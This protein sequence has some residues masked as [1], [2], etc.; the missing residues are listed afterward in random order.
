MNRLEVERCY[1]LCRDRLLAARDEHG[2]WRGELSSS[3]LSTAVAAFALRRLGGAARLRAALQGEAWL[4][5]TALADG[6]WGDTP[7]SPGNLSTTLLAWAALRGSPR[8][9]ASTAVCGAELWVHRQAGNLGPAAVA[10]AVLGHYGAD[11]T[12]AVPILSQCALA[13][14]LGESPACWRLVPQ[15]PFA[16]AVLPRATFGALGLP[17]VSYALPALIALGIVRQRCGPRAA[18]NWQRP[19]KPAALRRLARLQPASGGFLE[20]VPLTGFVAMSLRA[21]GLGDQPTATRCA[22]FLLAT[23]RAD[24]SWPIDSNLATWVSTLGTVSLGTDLPAA[25]RP[26]LRTWLLGQQFRQVHPYT[27]AA[28]GGWGWTDL[29]GS[30]PDADDTAGAL[31]ALPQLGPL[32]DPELRGAA[33][34][35]LT[36]LLGLANRDGGTPTF[37]RGWGRLP[38]DRS[39]PDITAHVLRAAAVWGPAVSPALR[40]RLD[41]AVPAA[42]RYLERSQRPD[43]SWLPLWFGNDAA[44][45]HANPVYG[46]ARVLRALSD[47][48]QLAAAPPAWVQRGLEALLARQADEGGWG[49]DLGVEPSVEETALAVTAL[50]RWPA[51]R[52]AA[53]RGVEWL[54]LHPEE[55]ERPRPIGLYFASLWYYEA[56]YPL[57]FATEALR[58]WLASPDSPL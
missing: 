55:I 19:F 32:A 7:V 27:G 57:L 38:F 48:P 43:G 9:G 24:G 50:L 1:Q 2:V 14:I 17:V 21:A 31:L 36:W 35:G 44:P 41:Q 49:G 54:V 3:A 22:E 33:E 42:L 56:L 47:L 26:A 5:R 10:A 29:P 58:E 20:A 28:P 16:L 40:R 25:G 34:A 30:V 23:Q 13:G 46:T 52:A 4:V 18:L 11:R 51:A 39:C 8:A 53:T 15:L 12:F 37:C 6:S 45:D